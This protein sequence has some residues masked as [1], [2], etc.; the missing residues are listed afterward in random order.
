[1]KTEYDVAT[2]NRRTPSRDYETRDRGV[3]TT[4]LGV[5]EGRGRMTD[6]LDL[7][8]QINTAYH[9]VR[10]EMDPKWKIIDLDKDLSRVDD[11]GDRESELRVRLHR[12]EAFV[13]G[14]FA[15][16][17]SGLDFAHRIVTEPMTKARLK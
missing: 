9:G 15:G 6:V 1:M 4:P 2:G 17:A 3:P 12:R 5:A 16:R 14:Y 13:D 11:D 8:V 7:S 10:K